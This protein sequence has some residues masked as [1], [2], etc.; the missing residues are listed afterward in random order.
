[1]GWIPTA[2]T[3]GSVLPWRSCLVVKFS[4][5]GITGLSLTGTLLATQ[6]RHDWKS[7]NTENN[8]QV[9]HLRLDLVLSQGRDKRSFFSIICGFRRTEGH[10]E[11]DSTSFTSESALEKLSLQILDINLMSNIN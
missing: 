9:V 6:M 2:G 3:V 7:A 11:T 10:L 5:V 4:Y 8:C 1:M